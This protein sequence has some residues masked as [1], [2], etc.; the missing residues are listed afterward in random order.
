MSSEI[1]KVVVVC[2]HKEYKVGMAYRTGGFSARHVDQCEFEFVSELAPPT[3]LHSK[4][5]NMFY[6]TFR[7]VSSAHPPIIFCLVRQM[8]EYAYSRD[9]G[10]H[11][12]CGRSRV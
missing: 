2:Q 5:L 9:V 6:G 1:W 4:F 3:I 8:F 12:W 7:K 11:I 10:I